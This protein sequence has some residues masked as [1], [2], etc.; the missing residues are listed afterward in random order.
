M[1]P[2]G[3]RKEESDG[4]GRGSEMREN[5][6]LNSRRSNHCSGSGVQ[7]LYSVFFTVVEQINTLFNLIMYILVNQ[8]RCRTFSPLLCNVVND[9]IVKKTHETL[10]VKWHW[11]CG[12]S[13]FTNCSLHYNMCR[14]VSITPNSMVS[15]ML[16]ISSE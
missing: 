9:I 5:S 4:C 13:I 11:T 10:S 15:S 7:F 12:G 1:D 14:E 3:V 6:R 16:S 2:W 8:S